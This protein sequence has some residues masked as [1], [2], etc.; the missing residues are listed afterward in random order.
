MHARLNFLLLLA[1]V[2]SS[3]FLVRTAYESRRLFTE[4]DRARDAELRLVGEHTRL[5]AEA[6]A[7]A[8]HL[9]VD[10]VARDK[11]AMRSATP[12]VTQAVVDADP[13]MVPR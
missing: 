2:A 3:L 1:L 11:L 13:A 10:R 7:Q 5:E 12:A 6:R 4:L 8:T 9:L